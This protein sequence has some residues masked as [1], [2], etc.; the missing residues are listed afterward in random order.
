M[1]AGTPRRRGGSDGTVSAVRGG[2]ARAV[3]PPRSHVPPDASPP[4]ADVRVERLGVG[5]AYQSPIVDFIERRRDCFDFVEVV[6]DILW[7]DLGS[8]RDPRYVEDSSRVR[9]LERLRAEVPVVPHS[10]GLSIGSAHRFDVEHVEQMRKWHERFDFPWH[11]DHLSYNIAP[12]ETG[13]RRDE[14]M[15]VGV[16]LPIPFD[17]ESIEF[18]TPRIVHIRS[19]IPK[20]FLLENN[21]VYFDL[22]DQE[23][24]EP[25]FLNRL[26]AKSGCGLLLDLHNLHT[27][28]RNHGFDPLRIL[29]RLDLGNVVE[30]HVAGGMEHK[31]F[32]LD[33]HSGPV[34]EPVWRLLEWTL[35]RCPHLGGVVFELFGSWF[36]DVGEERLAADLCRLKEMWAAHQPSVETGA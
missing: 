8:G 3:S 7:T 4:R 18:L 33:A 2:R 32:Y 19:C 20:P 24:D 34:P 23:F 11:S 6:P 10:I 12:Y 27:N 28:G 14:Q 35:P 31:G 16:T 25:E 5:I 1:R 30:L 9:F 22:P 36:V 29:D 15:N 17:E 21:V 13:D 26:C